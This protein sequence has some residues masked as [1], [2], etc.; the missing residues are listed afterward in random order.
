[1][2]VTP[3]QVAAA[4]K[5]RRSGASKRPAY[6]QAN[7]MLTLRAHTI[8]NCA[9]YLQVKHVLWHRS[10]EKVEAV[11][12]RAIMRAPYERWVGVCTTRHFM[13]ALPCCS[14]ALFIES[15]NRLRQIAIRFGRCQIKHLRRVI[16]KERCIQLHH[17]RRPSLKRLRPYLL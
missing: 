1:M 10:H 2:L 5:N 14:K 3:V 15:S 17:M 7:A 13:K 8:R 9:H 6:A 16:Y 12:R 4:S 11:S